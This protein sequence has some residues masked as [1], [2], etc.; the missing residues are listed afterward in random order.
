MQF[1]GQSFELRANG[2]WRKLRSTRSLEPSSKIIISGAMRRT[3]SKS[4][5]RSL[6]IVR[7]P[8]P[9]EMNLTYT[10]QGCI[11]MN[12]PLFLHK[13]LETMNERVPHYQ[14]APLG[15]ECRKQN[16]R[17]QKAARKKEKRV[18]RGARWNTRGAVKTMYV[19][20]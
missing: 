9:M 7:P 13:R 3:I 1:T 18:Q 15:L 6:A 10:I 11:S 14:Y 12:M 16:W 20:G 5:L 8:N 19:P 2:L 4:N 17:V